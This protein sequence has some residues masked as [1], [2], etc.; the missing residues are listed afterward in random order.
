MEIHGYC[1]ER[2]APVREAFEENFRARGDVGACFAATLEGEY[3][4]DLW[5]GHVDAACTRPWQED[6]IINVYSTTKTMTFLSALMLA[7]RGELDL[8][9]PVASYWPEFAAGGKS[10]VRVKHFLSHSA[11]LPGFSGPRTPAELY[12]WDSCCADLAAQAPWW[13]PGTQSGYHAITQ[14]Y[15]IG[16]VVRR[17]T[18]KSIGTWFREEVAG[19]LGADFH[20]GVN[21]AEF[22]RVADLVAAREPS[23]LLEMD[24][25]SIPGRVFMG[26][27]ISPETTGSEGWRRAE[28][29]AANGHGNAR[30]VVRAQTALANGGRAF[31]VELLSAAG[32][33]RALEPQTDGVD[34]VLGLPVRFA[35]GYAL[36]SEVVP[37]SPN[38]DTLWWGGA[39]GSTI[40]VDT[41]ARLCFSYVMNQMDNNI[42]GDP[43]GAS[44][45]AALYRS[46]E[47]AG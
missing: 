15:L 30:S 9:A 12:D 22:P 3:V 6:T 40:V 4:V 24:P 10:G 18:G 2:F 7:D 33:V 46:L 13:E 19:P 14:G 5:G 26:L 35:M 8:E 23:A 27:D 41:D 25:Q 1:D 45:G 11:G 32:C 43:R 34:A 28:I 20:I 31:G 21:P 47:S 16:E 37:V 29:P 42:V 17:V 36:P 44:L 38:S 39:G